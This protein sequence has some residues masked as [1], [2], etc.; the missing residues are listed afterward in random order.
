MKARKDVERYLAFGKNPHI[1][2]HVNEC[3]FFLQNVWL[4]A[5][6]PVVNGK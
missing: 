2:E 4:H 5:W 6:M 3:S 1:T